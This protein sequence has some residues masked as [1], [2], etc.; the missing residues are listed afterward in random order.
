MIAMDH[1]RRHRDA[2]LLAASERGAKN[3]RV[4]GSLAR[5]EGDERSDADFLVDMEPGRSV[6]DLAGLRAD[7]ERLLDCSVDV[8]TAAG[9]RDRIRDRVLD[10]ARPL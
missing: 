1:I 4:F 6:L 3:V 5:G 9:L 7:L 8:V 2:I 10:E